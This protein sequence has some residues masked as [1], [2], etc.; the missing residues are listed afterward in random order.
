MFYVFLTLGKVKKAKKEIDKGPKVW[1][2]W[3]KWSD[4]TVTCGFGK[5][6]RWRHCV[7]GGCA[8]GEKEAQIKTCT[9]PAC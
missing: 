1:D 5:M 7:S 3:G 6:T 2:H 8:S 9:N 4:C